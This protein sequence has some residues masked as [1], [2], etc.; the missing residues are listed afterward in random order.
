MVRRLVV[1]I[2]KLSLGLHGALHIVELGTALYEEAY[3]TASFALFGTFT[4][5]AGA[6]LLTPE[7]RAHHH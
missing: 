6:I 7:E 5:L 2:V 4:M 1:Q 3:I